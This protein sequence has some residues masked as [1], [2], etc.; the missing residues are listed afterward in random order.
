MGVLASFF[1]PRRRVDPSLPIERPAAEFG[2]LGQTRLDD[3]MPK[4]QTLEEDRL[5]RIRQRETTKAMA[6]EAMNAL[7]PMDRNLICMAYLCGLEP[8]EMRH[9][10]N[11]L[12][13]QADEKE[14]S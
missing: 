3:N 9:F 11:Q 14:R 7:P 4:P 12:G 5:D 6:R 13:R 10:S 1:L 8:E 2:I